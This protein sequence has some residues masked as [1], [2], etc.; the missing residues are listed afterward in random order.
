MKDYYEILGVSKE[1][2]EEEIKSAYRKLANKYHPDVSKDKNATEKMAEVNEAYTTLKDPEKRAA[3]DQYGPSINE[4]AQADSNST[5]YYYYPNGN[6]YDYNRGYFYSKS[7]FSLGKFLFRIILIFLLFNALLSLGSILVQ[8]ALGYE[9][10]ATEIA[11]DQIDFSFELIGNSYT[12]VKVTRLSRYISDTRIQ[13][14]EIPSTI[15]SRGANYTVKEIGANAFKNCTNLTSIHIPST[16]TTI[17][18]YA[19]YR[20]S[21]LG[22]IYYHGTEEQF[23]QIKIGTGN[24]YLKDATIIFINFTI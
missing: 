5:T 8:R 14:I 16:V 19:F 17:G 1:A 24:P 15:N 23:N 9:S 6:Y 21:K 10:S 18:D 20:C 2:S 4:N 11:K 7:A 12:G 22:T 3:Y 13:S